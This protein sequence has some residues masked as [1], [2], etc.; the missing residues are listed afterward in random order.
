MR[1][2]Q[3]NIPPNPLLAPEA[4]ANGHAAHTNGNGNGNGKKTRRGLFGGKREEIVQ[5]DVDAYET[6]RVARSA[7]ADVLRIAYTFRRAQLKGT[8]ANAEELEAVERAYALLTDAEQRAMYDRINIGRHGTD[9]RPSVAERIAS[10]SKPAIEEAPAPTPDAAELAVEAPATTGKQSAQDA[11][12]VDGAAPAVDAVAADNEDASGSVTTADA[13]AAATGVDAAAADA[14]GEAEDSGASESSPATELLEAVP[15]AAETPAVADEAVGQPVA[16]TNGV[17][18]IEAVPPIVAEPE[19]DGFEEEKQ[20]GSRLTS[21]LSGM[22]RRPPVSRVGHRLDADHRLEVISA[23]DEPASREDIE[24]AEQERLMT[25][26][27]ESLGAVERYDDIVLPEPPPRR[28]PPDHSKAAAFIEFVSG[29]RA[30]ELIG[31]DGDILT[32]GTSPRS[33][34]ILPDEQG[35]IAREHARIWKHGDNFLLRE[36]DGAGTTI[37]GHSLE[38]PVVVLEDG[39]NVQI[40]PYK[41]RFTL[42]KAAGAVDG[43]LPDADNRPSAG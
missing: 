43:A 12:E 13:A 14:A 38:T 34:V 20:N 29:M 26:R 19:D 24:R 31:L 32:L 7:S 9:D 27:D 33:G 5:R 35:A 40:G 25:L 6:L 22:F 41:M 16:A 1:D 17:E 30:G 2:R 23:T 18:P 21:K 15:T 10:I 11:T 4:R 8:A 36:V 42:A 37:G 3:G 28:P 39:D